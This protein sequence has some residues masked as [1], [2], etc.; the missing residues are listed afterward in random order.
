[1]KSRPSTCWCRYTSPGTRHPSRTLCSS[2]SLTGTAPPSSCGCAACGCAACGCAAKLAASLSQRRRMHKVSSHPFVFRNN[3]ESVREGSENVRSSLGNDREGHDR[4]VCGCAAC[5]CAVCGCAAAA[6]AVVSVV[7]AVTVL[8]V[9]AQINRPLAPRGR[10]SC[11]RLLRSDSCP[12]QSL[13]ASSSLLLLLRTTRHLQ[14]DRGRQT[15][16]R[17]RLLLPRVQGTLARRHK[18]PGEEGRASRDAAFPLRGEPEREC[19]RARRCAG[20]RSARSERPQTTAEEIHIARNTFSGFTYPT[21]SVP[22]QREVHSF[23]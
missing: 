15:V 7:V 11:H 19:G 10:S 6:A 17:R 1:M 14:E 5:G 21:T 4:A 22:I 12:S 18:G 3:K 8:A 16:A 9:E 20:A 13:C 23:G 2:G